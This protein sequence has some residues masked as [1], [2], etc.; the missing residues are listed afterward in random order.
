[1][2]NNLSAFNSIEDLL[3]YLLAFMLALAIAMSI[4]EFAHAKVAYILGDDT[5]KLSG[6]LTL[7]PLA[8]ISPIGLVCFLLVGYGWATPVPVNPLRFKKYRLGM[9]L[10]SIAG[11]ITNF[12]FAFIT[13]FKFIQKVT[14]AETFFY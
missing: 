9:F 8:H 13:Q 11:V 14:L 7:N 6:R 5:A 1:M 2:L 10:V 4:H 12:I 3:P